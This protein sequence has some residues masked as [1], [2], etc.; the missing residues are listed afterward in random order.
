MVTVQKAGLQSCF[1]DVPLLTC[2]CNAQGCQHRNFT[3]DLQDKRLAKEWFLPLGSRLFGWFTTGQ[4][5]F[6]L[7]ELAQGKYRHLP[8]AACGGW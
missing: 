2:G 1:L 5:L 7:L 6:A 4:R 3:C 8:P